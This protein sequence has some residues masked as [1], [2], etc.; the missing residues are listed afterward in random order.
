M[1]EFESRS[2][3]TRD[4]VEGFHLL[5]NSHKLCQGFQQAM[6]ARKTCFISFMKLLFSVLTKR[7]MIYEARTVNSY[8]SETVNQI[9][10]VIFMLHSSTGFP[11][12]QGNQGK[13]FLL[14]SSQGKVREFA[15]NALDQGKVREF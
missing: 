1:G 3:K 7:K 4:A 13:L 10:H 9:A 2:V 5:E 6:E 11:A 15:K 8:N 14:F 12:H